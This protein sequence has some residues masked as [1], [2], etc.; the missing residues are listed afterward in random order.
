MSFQQNLVDFVDLCAE[1]RLCK[2]LI[3]IKNVRHVVLGQK[4]SVSGC[5]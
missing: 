5:E 2:I 1:R 4:V 3:W